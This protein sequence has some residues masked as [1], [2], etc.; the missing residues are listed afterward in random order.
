MDFF[1]P[2]SIAP[3]FS[4]DG[5]LNELSLGKVCVCLEIATGGIE[6]TRV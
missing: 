6:R 1:F 2:I 4:F 5:S 3:V